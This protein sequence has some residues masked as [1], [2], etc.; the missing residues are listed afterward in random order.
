MSASRQLWSHLHTEQQSTAQ[1]LLAGCYCH[2]GKSRC[3][4]AL[5]ASECQYYDE[6]G[7]EHRAGVC[8]YPRNA[9]CLVIEWIALSK[10]KSSK[11][12][13]EETE[14]KLSLAEVVNSE[15]PSE[16]PYSTHSAK[17]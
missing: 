12:V 4:E 16:L 5:S 17:N 2:D 3:L 6:E 13:Y 7:Y 11:M 8:L 9:V 15:I 14:G 10:T 1:Q